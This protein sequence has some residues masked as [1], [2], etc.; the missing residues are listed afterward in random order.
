MKGS[1]RGVKRFLMVIKEVTE[2]W[3]GRLKLQRRTTLPA[4]RLSDY[5][6]YSEYS[7]NSDYSDY[8]ESSD[9]P[10]NLTYEATL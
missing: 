4:C 3:Q 5:S 8:S 9:R 1:K 2:K 6:D 10:H 7:D